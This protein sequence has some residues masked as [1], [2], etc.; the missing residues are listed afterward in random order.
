LPSARATTRRSTQLPWKIVD[1]KSYLH[2]DRGVQRRWEADIPGRIA[3]G[4][5]NWPSVAARLAAR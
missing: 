1:G 3:K 2:H 5:A 4:D